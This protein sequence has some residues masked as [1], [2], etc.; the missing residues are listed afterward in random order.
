[1]K[2][3]KNEVLIEFTCDD[4]KLKKALKIIERIDK[5]HGEFVKNMAGFYDS[6]KAKSKAK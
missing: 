3:T 4:S 1:M 2:N 6:I 5:L